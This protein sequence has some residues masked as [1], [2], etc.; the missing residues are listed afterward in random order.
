MKTRRISFTIL[1][2]L[3]TGFWLTAWGGVKL[4][5]LISDGMVLQ[6][7]R[8]VKIWGWAAPG[9]KITVQFRDH[10]RKTSA[11]ENGD[12]QIILT[13]LQAGGPYEMR[14]H[15]SNDVTIRDILIGD[16]WVCSGQSNMVLPMQRV[17]DL[18]Q[19]EMDDSENAFIRYFRIPDH[20]DFDQPQT[21]VR[22][23]EWQSANPENTS[24]FS[25]VA[26]FFAK[27]MVDRYDVPVGII[28]ASVGGSPI[29]AWMSEEALKDFPGHL[30]TLKNFRDSAYV[31]Q[32]VR[33]DRN[34]SDAWHHRL[35]QN[36]KGLG[37]G[38]SW[39]DTAYDASGWPVMT[40]PTFWDETEAGSI[41]GVIWFRKEVYIPE[42]MAGQPAM[43]R[44]GRIVDADFVYL[45]GQQVGST[46]Y[47]YPPRKYK[48]DRNL[49]KAGKNVL[50]VRVVNYIGRGG[51]IKDKPYRLMT[52]EDVIDL[53]GGWQ[54]RIGA[55]MG[56]RAVCGTHC[57]IA[58]LERE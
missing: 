49:L 38:I 18:Y 54:Y 20:Y 13:G 34:R 27:T 35:Q 41:N 47:Q 57:L 53:K 16:I 2:F 32:I 11:D 40:L 5:R 8:D 25:A 39:F 45:N 17:N 36:D 9:E 37:H 56:Q 23:G 22:S 15:A 52:G 19:K 33:K 46:S 48:L 1:F 30:E 28:N 12:W 7:N 3:L 21:D 24:R 26:Y 10:I 58:R 43:L 51:F 55:V 14:I 29:E 4:P 44:L 31:N 42:S 50:A 6:R